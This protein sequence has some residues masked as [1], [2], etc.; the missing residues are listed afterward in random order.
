MHLYE[1]ERVMVGGRSI[2]QKGTNGIVNNTIKQNLWKQHTE[3]FR[4]L[5]ISRKQ[6]GGFY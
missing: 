5:Q 2:I 4:K 6:K 1:G 3:F